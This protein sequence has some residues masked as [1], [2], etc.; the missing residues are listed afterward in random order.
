[1]VGHELMRRARLD[2]RSLVRVAVAATVAGACMPATTGDPAMAQIVLEM[3]DAVN[4][5][6]QENA[7]LQAQVDS[8]AILVAKQDTVVRNLAAAAGITMPR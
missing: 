5:L 1:M 4:E 2:W 3:G 6:R 8:L 7:I